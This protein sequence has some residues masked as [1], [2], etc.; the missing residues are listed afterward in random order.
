MH[1]K[2][3]PIILLLTVLIFFLSILFYF[4]DA[5]NF[6]IGGATAL[7]LLPII[8]AFSMFHSPLT[9]C[10][11][12]LACGIFMDACMLGAYGFNAVLLMLIGVF[13]SLTSNNLFNKNIWASLVLSLIV[14]LFYFIMHWI[15]FHT[16]NVSLK[17]NLMY[18]LKYAVPSAIYSA[19]F[20]IIFYYIF[21]HFHKIKSE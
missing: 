21:K 2:R 18:L 6:K 8:T 10:F 11:T 1:K 16:A 20:I 15:F 19:V 13:V 5:L 3:H 4:T 7:L 9:C 14:S 17:D 12:G